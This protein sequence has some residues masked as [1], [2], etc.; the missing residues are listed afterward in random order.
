M[1]AVFKLNMV[2]TFNIQQGDHFNNMV[3]EYSTIAKAV[4]SDNDKDG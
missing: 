4:N 1:E 2:D 3:N